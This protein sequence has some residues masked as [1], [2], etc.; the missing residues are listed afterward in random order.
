MKYT[1]GKRNV[2]QSV[3]LALVGGAATLASGV[4]SAN[5]I[6]TS[7]FHTVT[8][9]ATPGEVT[10][11]NR[12]FQP[13][14]FRTPA[15][16]TTVELSGYVRAQ[17]TYDLEDDLGDSFVVSSIPTG[18]GEAGDGHVR[19][20][21]RRS[22]FR[23]KSNTEL[24]GG[25][26]VKTHLEGD[27]FGVG[28]NQSFSNSTALRLRIAS[29]NV[30]NWTFGQTWTNFM[31][32]VAYPTTVDFFG[33]A[34]KSFKRIPQIRYTF[35]NGLSFSLENPETDGVGA[36]GRIRESTGGPGQDL[37]PD[38]TAAWRGG[39]GGAGGSYEISAVARTLG[40]EGTFTDAAGNDISVDETLGGFGFL[41]AGAWDFGFGTVAAS[42]TTGDGIGSFIING[43]GN[44]IFV[45]D[46]GDV[47]TITSTGVA[48]SYKHN[49]SDKASTL[50]SFGGFQNI[51]DDGEN[52]GIDNLQTIHVNY[53]WKTN[54]GVT[55]GAE[56]IAGNLETP[57][58]GDPSSVD[59]GTATRLTF[60]AQF[61][62]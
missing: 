41:A 12:L 15:G 26:Q 58:A 62:F 23:I 29:I 4:V 5:D 16:E 19:F 30:G 51:D 28:G 59:S 3:A 22:R 49:W 52:N 27:F 37:L 18:D 7:P 9:D 13:L 8:N 34:G 38:I 2:A 44:D 46:T 56:I 24:A 55:Y 10:G 47:S 6:R 20:Q 35:D 60:G 53:I 32:F 45:D 14:T 40:V 31:D 11:D 1:F 25:T 57:Q 39:P 50:I 43:F 42:I 61:N 17:F 21:A 36:L 48:L 54:A 33:P